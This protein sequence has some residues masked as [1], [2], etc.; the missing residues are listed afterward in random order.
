M[1]KIP[2]LLAVATLIPIGALS[3]LGVRII[4]QDRDVER[5]RRREALEVS[6]GRLALEIERKL[7]QIEDQLGK[8]KGIALAPVSDEEAPDS[9]FTETE[10][11]EFRRRDLNAAAAAYRGLAESSKPPVRAAALV[12]LGRVLR[13][14]GDRPGAL[15]VYSNL[16]QLG[17]ATVGGLPA[18]LVGWQGRCRVLVEA[19]DVEGLRTEAVKLAQAL[20]SGRWPADR[21]TFDLYRVMVQGWGAPP[22]SRDAIARVEAAIELRSAWNGGRLAPRG[23]RILHE[24]DAAVLAVWSGG[25]NNATAWIVTVEDFAASLR[26][27]WVDQQLAVSLYDSDGRRVLGEPRPGAVSLTPGETRLPFIVSVASLARERGGGRVVLVSGLALA[28]LAMLAAGF[29]L[30]R[31]TTREVALARRQSDFVSAVSHEFRTPLTS[32]RHLTDLLVS[33]SIAS[34]ER[35][36]QYYELLANETGRLHRMVESLLSFG[37]IEVGAYAWHLERADTARFVQGLVEE[38]RLAPEARD[39]VVSCRIEEGLPPIQADREALSRALWNLLENAAKYSA[40]GSPIR[41]AARRQ[42]NSVLLAVEDEGAGIPVGERERIFQKFVRGADAKQTGVRGV[43]IGL[44]L[45]KRIVEAHGGTVRLESEPGRGS[46]FTLVLP[47][48]EF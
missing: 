24:A 47:C 6:A 37:R 12:R 30:Y 4:Q 41:V 38:F 34:E 32:M 22:P 28:F 18:D 10:A 31:A 33:R 45:V 17:S 7:Q 39:R 3:W 20:D 2:L 36:A 11:V 46:T 5:Q 21:A 9:L 26:S 44:A 19:R 8:G 25:P 16:E 35:K 23:R 15:K 13:Q 27:L 43:G 42:G 48:P 40:A 1:R 14:L 29:A